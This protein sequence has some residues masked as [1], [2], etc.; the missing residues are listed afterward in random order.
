VIP[1]RYGRQRDVELAAL[2]DPAVRAASHAADV[3]LRSYAALTRA[4]D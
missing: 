3:E 1:S 2:T 4:V